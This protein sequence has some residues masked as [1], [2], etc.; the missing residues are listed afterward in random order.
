MKPLPEPYAKKWMVHI[1]MALYFAHGK[2]IAHRD[3]KLENFLLDEKYTALLSDFGMA[4]CMDSSYAGEMLSVQCGTTDYMAP[5]LHIASNSNSTYDPFPAD[6]YSMGICLFEMVNYFRPFNISVS[7]SDL[8]ILYRQRR[9]KYVFNKKIY[10]TKECHDLLHQMLDPTPESRPTAISVLEDVWLQNSIRRPLPWEKLH[11]T[12][13]SNRQINF[14]KFLI[15][16]PP[17]Q[18]V[19]NPRISLNF[20]QIKFLILSS[21][22]AH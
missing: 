4:V 1:M 6:I 15:N 12:F 3:L 10:L 16:P 8:S 5:E 7:D 13:Q 17:K 9:R 22:L 2:Q 20:Q 21:S 18:L 11:H 14:N 19:D